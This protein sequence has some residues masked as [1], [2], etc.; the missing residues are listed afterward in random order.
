MSPSRPRIVA[1]NWKMHGSRALLRALVPAV[2][3]GLPAAGRCQV[4]FCP[5][6]VYL[7]ELAGLLQ[8]PRCAV[9]GQDVSAHVSGAYTGELAAAMLLES[10]C[11]Y[12]I[13][14]HSE[15]RRYHGESSE[16]VAAKATAAL[17]AGL[18]PIICIG[19]TLADRESGRTWAVL[20][21]QLTAV[22]ELL[23]QPRASEI[24]LAYEPVWAIGT[25]RTATPEQAQDVHAQVRNWLQEQASAIGKPMLAGQLPI[26]YGGSVK[27][28][29]AA[30][31]M[32][33]PDVDGALVGG[34]SLQADEFIA[35]CR[36]AD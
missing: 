31:L 19:E 4:V 30:A 32:A 3:Q 15:R 34:A 25:G 7:G 21:A 35:I 33:Q 27:A 1:G 13:V 12:A 23:Q 26:L 29:N 36:S 11:R 18:L 28:D 16:L 2:Q 20:S 5:P 14:G 22:A 6:A 8:H 17:S 9:G 24:V 10:G